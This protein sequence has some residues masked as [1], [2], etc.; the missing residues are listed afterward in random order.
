M[1]AQCITFWSLLPIADFPRWLAEPHQ[2][3]VIDYLQE[4]NRIF[5]EQLGGKQLR[6]NDDQCRRLALRAKKL[7]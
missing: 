5:R 4:R 1:M 7:S 3:D 2:Q 6:F